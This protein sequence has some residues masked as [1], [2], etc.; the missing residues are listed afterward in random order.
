MVVHASG[1]ESVAAVGLDAQDVAVVPVVRV[2]VGHLP[3][4]PDLEGSVLRHRVELVVLPVK[5]DAGDGVAVTQERLN[6]LLVVNVPDAY[7]SVFASADEVL[8]VWRDSG[9]ENLVVVAFMITV[10]PFPSEKV[11]FHASKVPLDERAV[12]G[13]RDKTFVI[14]LPVEAGDRP[15]V[16]LHKIPLKQAFVNNLFRGCSCSLLSFNILTLL[17]KTGKASELVGHLVKKFA[18]FLQQMHLH[19]FGKRVVGLLVNDVLLLLGLRVQFHKEV[20][21]VFLSVLGKDLVRHP[22]ALLL[23]CLTFILIYLQEWVIG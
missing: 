13:A 2:H 19:P 23:P 1:E 17:F 12:F 21:L 8:S 4:V 15:L 7:D 22:K 20:S 5:C 14:K 3:Q 9:A 16:T 18:L 10:E 11:F 6:L